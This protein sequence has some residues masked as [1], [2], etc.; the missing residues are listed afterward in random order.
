ME[1]DPYL[2]MLF[3]I[4][5]CSNYRAGPLPGSRCLVSFRRVVAIAMQGKS[6]ATDSQRMHVGIRGGLEEEEDAQT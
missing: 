1:I 5:Q 6:D 4:S 3:F 2:P